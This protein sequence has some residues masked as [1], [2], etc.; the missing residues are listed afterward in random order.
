MIDLNTAF[1]VN[2]VW[3]TWD[4]QKQSQSFLLTFLFEWAI[5]FGEPSTAK[6]NIGLSYEAKK[7]PEN[8]NYVMSQASMMV[9][10]LNM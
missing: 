2:C 6:Q 7:R 8:L 3:E 10:H 9:Y 1:L 5:P 4:F